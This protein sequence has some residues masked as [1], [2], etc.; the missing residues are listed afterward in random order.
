[1]AH[2][3]LRETDVNPVVERAETEG[4]R[5]IRANLGDPTRFGIF[6]I[7]RLMHHVSEAYLDPHNWGYGPA[8]GIPELRSILAEGNVFFGTKGYTLPLNHVFIGAGISGVARGLLTALINPANGDEVVIPKWSYIIY[9]AEAA[10]SGAKVRNVDLTPEALVD[11]DKLK[12]TI[13]AKTK[14]VFITTVGN[15]LGVAMP[16]KTFGEIIRIVNAKEKEFNHAI[17]LIADTIYEDFR[18]GP[19]LDPILL[20]IQNNRIGPTIELYSVSKMFAAP[21]LRLGWMRV[22]HNKDGFSADVRDF[23][24]GFTNCRQP[25]LGPTSTAAQL[26]VFR[27]ASEFENE[28]SRREITALKDSRRMDIRGRVRAINRALAAIDGVVPMEREYPKASLDNSFYIVPGIDPRLCPPES[29]SQASRL[30]E[31]NRNRSDTVLATTPA[32][33][34][35]AKDY[36]DEHIQNQERFRIVALDTT[37]DEVA[38]SVGGFVAHLKSKH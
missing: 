21:G 2:Y 22:Y 24:N 9:L 6:P 14:A 31:F 17:Y 26:G 13:N 16:H 23:C 1:L 37:P 19:P 29:L 4:K 12:N 30:A 11:L 28:A 5:I 32:A 15:P 8:V 35:L 34:F 38:E 33:H 10:L 36:R 25:S 7:P 27:T 18:V 3:T 20:S